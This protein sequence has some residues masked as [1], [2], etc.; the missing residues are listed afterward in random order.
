MSE[1]KAN[2][3]ETKS[4][5]KVAS[6]APSD[7]AT[8]TRATLSTAIQDMM[9][10]AVTGSKSGSDS[11]SPSA[12]GEALPNAVKAAE[13]TAANGESMSVPGKIAENHAKNGMQ[14]SIGGKIAEGVAK[15]GESIKHG[16]EIHQQ[17]DKSGSL[18]NIIKGGVMINDFG[19]S[20]VTDADRKE[21]KEALEKGISGLVPEADRK[22][23]VALQNAII[24]GD[25]AKFQEAVKALGN[26]PEKLEKMVKE[27]NDQ[28]NRNEKFGGVELSMDSKGNVLLYGEKGN[29]AVS[30][31]PKTG[32][33]TLR[34][35]EQQADGSV[36][37]KDG[38]IINRKAG[39]V[40]KDL[41]DQATRSITDF[42]FHKLQ[43]M[44]KPPFRDFPNPD[45]TF[46]GKD[47]HRSPGWPQPR[48]NDGKPSWKENL[49]KG[50]GKTGTGHLDFTPLKE[51]EKSSDK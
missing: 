33:A 28:L 1:A 3:V 46:P 32:E 6:Q 15:N 14:N 31:N 43:P 4:D 13:S 50:D 48:D 38:E 27:V 35:V 19:K 49:L 44:D 24:D 11:S 18:E 16:G 40:M 26:D 36:V 21:A 41:G 45:R 34:A 23:Q 2:Q 5:A 29:T 47:P 7:T 22:V 10:E 25:M 9:K 20:K 37:L 39:E 17:I 8:D 30:V 12:V 51:L 42:P